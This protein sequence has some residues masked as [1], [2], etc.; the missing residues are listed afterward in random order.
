MFLFFKPLPR[1]LER[2]APYGWG[3]GTLPNLAAKLIDSGFPEDMP[4]VAVERG[5]TPQERRVFSTIGELPG[6]VAEEQLKSP[7]LI[8]VGNTVALSPWWPWQSEV[9]NTTPTSKQSEA[10]GVKYVAQSGLP[11][12]DTAS[13]FEE[14][15]EV[16]KKLRVLGQGAH[17]SAEEGQAVG[18]GAR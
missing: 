6:A 5:T 8:I 16:V 11:S 1:K 10:R 13:W 14:N 17:D 7:T 3:L 15:S 18:G 9:G 2:V 12:E 4:A